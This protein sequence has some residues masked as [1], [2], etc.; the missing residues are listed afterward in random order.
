MN[1]LVIGSL[2]PP[3]T[4]R[5]RALLREVLAQR[6]TGATVEVV[7]PT[8][9]AV[10]H[11]YLELSGAGAAVEIALAV[12]RVDRVVVQLEPGFPL[13]PGAG[14]ARRALGLGALA[15]ALRQAR[16]EVVLRLYDAL[17]L[18]QGLGGRPALALWSLATRI[19]VGDADTA[20]VLSAVL[21]AE[22]AS[23]VEVDVSV[24]DGDSSSPRG[25]ESAGDPH[26]TPDLASATRLVR[27][28]TADVRT[29]VLSPRDPSGPAAEQTVLPLW[30]WV[31]VPGAGV[32]EWADAAPAPGD[33]GSLG[34]RAARAVLYAA[35]RSELT[36]PLARGARLARRVVSKV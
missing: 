13:P 25:H 12:R 22:I 2:P 36:R 24:R 28:R 35:E 30:Q 18:P 4:P 17:D 6:A 23:R 26:A 16:G 33:P 19:E 29:R 31:P 1:V 5:S 8:P 15:T 9:Y 3:A 14:R 34:R 21:P 11:R 27:A 10:A 32:P 7:S 20:E